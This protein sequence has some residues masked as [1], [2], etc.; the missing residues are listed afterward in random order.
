MD[1]PYAK[2]KGKYAAAHPVGAVN[3]AKGSGPTKGAAEKGKHAAP[4]DWSHQPHNSAWGKGKQ[5]DSHPTWG[6]SD[7]WGP[8]TS[9]DQWPNDATNHWQEKPKDVTDSIQKTTED[10]ESKQKGYKVWPVATS[11]KT[12]PSHWVPPSEF[13]RQRFF[14]NQTP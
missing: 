1:G 11:F 3:H 4:Q 7:A 6:S 8:G 13:E 2:G 5:W 12:T 10:E 9:W 14:A